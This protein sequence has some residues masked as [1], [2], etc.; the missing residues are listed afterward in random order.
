MKILGIDPGIA[1][2]WALV[3]VGIGKDKIILCGH[4]KTLPR[5]KKGNK[6]NPYGC[7]ADWKHLGAELCI[8]EQSQPMPGQGVTSV[9][10]YGRAFG[11]IEACIA[12]LGI[13]V[14]RVR[15]QVWKKAAGL[16]KQDKDRSRTKVIEMFPD[17]SGW[18]QLKKDG[19]KAEAV[20][21]AIYG[22]G[23]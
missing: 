13:A 5:A 8:L 20:L 1:G 12:S 22:S 19:H 10:Q 6:I 3:D 16:L 11:N 21:I 23:L 14:Q 15:P 4:L 9:F 2:G 17:K 18:F 7:L